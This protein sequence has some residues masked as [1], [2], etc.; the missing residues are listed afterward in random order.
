M[1]AVIISSPGEADVLTIQERPQPQIQKG[2]VLISVRAA[3]VNRPDIMQRQGKYPAPDGAPKDIPGL[4]VAGIISQVSD[5]E[6]RWKVGDKVCALV[7]GGG[8]AEYVTAPSRQCLPIPNGLGFVE[9]ASLPETFFT[10]W[11][12]VF[13]RVRFKEGE[14]FLIHG[15]TS[16][17]G[18]TAIQM[19]KAMGGK[20]Y[21]TAGTKVKCEFAEEIGADRAINYREE[22]FE[23]VINS[24]ETGGVDIILDMIG[25]DYTGKNINILKVEG[26]LAIINAMKNRK[27]EV[28]LMKVMVKRLVITGSTL[29]PRDVNFKHDIA[30]QL[31]K[32]IWPLLAAKKIKP[33]IYKTFPLEQASDAHL[34]MESSEHIGKIVLTN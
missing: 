16:G 28:D 24:E 10:V 2:E 8:Y 21:A 29:R 23:E 1:K 19:V 4:E 31:E 9:A 7:A 15:G 32:N 20:V 6:K 18:V 34:L 14:V 26:R 5:D 11:T 27:A 3:G 13:D 12:N 17:I 22:D 30:V 33:V 25:G